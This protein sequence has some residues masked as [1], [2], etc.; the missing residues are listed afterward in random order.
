MSR[1][2]LERLCHAVD[3]VS[4]V[5][6]SQLSSSNWVIRLHTIVVAGS[7]ATLGG[8]RLGVVPLD[9][10]CLSPSYL[11]LCLAAVSAVTLGTTL[12]G[13]G[14]DVALA[15]RAWCDTAPGDILAEHRDTA[16]RSGSRREEAAEG[17]AASEAAHEAGGEADSGG[18]AADPNAV[19]A[20]ALVARAVATMDTAVNTKDWIEAKRLLGL[21]ELEATPASPLQSCEVVWRIG[22]CDFEMSQKLEAELTVSKDTAKDAECKALILSAYAH[23]KRALVFDPG[24]SSAHKWCGICLASSGQYKSVKEKIADAAGIRDH[25]KSALALSPNDAGLQ[26]MMGEFGVAKVDERKEGRKEGRKERRADR[27]KA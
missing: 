6:D 26:H 21:L 9:A 5:E 7:L 19:A 27:R 25:T 8:I 12:R 15:L 2:R 20:D 23:A 16:P 18:A 3:L 22:R 1:A 13:P 24:S 10:M 17:A 11:L 4:Q 14:P